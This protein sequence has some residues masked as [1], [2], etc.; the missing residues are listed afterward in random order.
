MRF[1]AI[2]STALAA[3]CLALSVWLF[4]ASASNQSLQAEMQRKQTEMQTQ[5]Q[6]MQLQV[7]QLQEQQATINQGMQLAQQIG[8][9]VLRDLGA[10]A[11]QNKNEKIRTLLSKYGLSIQENAEG[12]AAGGSPAPEAGSATAP[13]AGTPTPAPAAS[14][15][16]TAPATR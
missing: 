9:N 15:R 3:I 8:P 11:V 12:A 4:F 10:M 6:Q 5:Q 7:Q 2:L 1:P 14:P 13:P 16:A